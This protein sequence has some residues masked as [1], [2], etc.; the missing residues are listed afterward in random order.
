MVK[1]N[2]GNVMKTLVMSGILAMGLMGCQGQSPFKRSADLSK[3]YPNASAAGTRYV[4]GQTTVKPAAPDNSQSVCVSAFKVSVENDRGS[5]LMIFT[6]DSS[7]T[8]NI[9]IRSFGGSNFDIQAERPEGSVF[10]EIS[11]DGNVRTYSFTWK[12]G[13]TV[14]AQVGLKLLSLKYLSSFVKDTCGSDAR[15]ELNLVVVKTDDIPALTIKDLPQTELV[16]GAEPSVF[17]IE[18]NDPASTSASAP[19]LKDF[20]FREEVRSGERAVSDASKAVSCEQGKLISGT[21]WEFICSFDTKKIAGI[22][23]NKKAE[24]KVDTLFFATAVSA[25]TNR[26]S[27]PTPGYVKVSIPKAEVVASVSKGAKK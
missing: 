26:A 9:N 14:S 4:P 10:K 17:K 18:V 27:A 24:K 21:T 2:K 12:P 7:S 22:K 16:W 8:Y 1:V 3:Q 20:S 25:R 15:E 23:Q 6:E 13:K 5:K 19:K 11:R